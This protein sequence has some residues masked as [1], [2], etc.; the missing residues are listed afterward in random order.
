MKSCPAGQQNNIAYSLFWKCL[1]AMDHAH[2]HGISFQT[3]GWETAKL[4]SSYVI[5]LMLDT[6]KTFDNKLV[7]C[8]ND[9][10][11]SMWMEYKQ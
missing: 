6:E 11:S 9:A 5:I 3:Q 7:Q 2:S 10:L 4:H 8:T 1:S